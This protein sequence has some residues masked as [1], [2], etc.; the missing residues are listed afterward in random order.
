MQGTLIKTIEEIKVNHANC[1]RERLELQTEVGSL[2]ST[3]NMYRH[4]QSTRVDRLQDQLN[5]QNETLNLQNSTL[6]GLIR[7]SRATTGSL[8][9]QATAIEVNRVAIEGID[10]SIPKSSDGEK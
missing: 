3:F 5:K 8:R 2:Q 1:E 6:A 9:E 4:E 10:P 7:S